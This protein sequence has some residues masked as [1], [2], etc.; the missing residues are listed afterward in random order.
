MK[1]KMIFKVLGAG[2]LGLGLALN[3]QYALNDYGLEEQ[4]LC[5][6]VLAQTDGT[7]GG[8]ETGGGNYFTK[9]LVDCVYSGIG[10]TPGSTVTVKDINGNYYTVKVDKTGG[11]KFISSYGRI[12]CVRGGGDTCIPLDCPPLS[13]S[14]T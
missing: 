8:H 9:M 11:W 4:S 1:K 5:V 14:G 12:E 6:A 7:S 13:G 3:I 10:E 2:I